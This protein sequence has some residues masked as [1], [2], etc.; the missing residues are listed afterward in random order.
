MGRK[1]GTVP[2]LGGGAGSPCNTMRPGPRPTFVPS[3][4]LIHSAVWAQQKWAEIW[5]GA[6]PL[7]GEAGSA[8]NRMLPGPRSSIVPSGILIHP[9]I[10]PQ[11]TWAET[12]RLCPLF[13][14]GSWVPIWHNV[15]WAEAYVY[16]KWH[17]D[18]SSPLGTLDMGQKFG[19][20]VFPR[21]GR[22]AGSPFNTTSLG[23]RITFLP[24]GILIHLSTTDM[25]RKLGA[26]HLCGR[27]TWVPI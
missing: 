26:M 25:G 5:R 10:W 8:S 24:S 20:N 6:V 13:G 21:L 22:G 27:L 19:V 15:A 1:L 16:T 3:G 11:Q 23:S 17:L 7:G 4:I 14:E 9:A 12:W 2:L 18:P